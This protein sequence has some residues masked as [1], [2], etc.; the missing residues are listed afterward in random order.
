MLLFPLK[1]VS[2]YDQEKPQSRTADKP[3]A[4]RGRA[5]Q[6]LARHQEDKLSKATATSPL[7]PMKMIAKQ[8]WTERNA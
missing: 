1:I 6:Q 4:P 8:E 7:F 3:M 2:E 5:T